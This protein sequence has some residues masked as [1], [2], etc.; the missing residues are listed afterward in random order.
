MANC[1]GGAEKKGYSAYRI[2]EWDDVRVDGV[3]VQAIGGIL[4]C[5]NC[6]VGTSSDEKAIDVDAWWLRMPGRPNM[7]REVTMRRLSQTLSPRR[8]IVIELLITGLQM[9]L[10]L[11]F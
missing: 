8:R 11:V 5:R 9:I 7:K 10:L 3:H 1:F 2:E 6:L 4:L